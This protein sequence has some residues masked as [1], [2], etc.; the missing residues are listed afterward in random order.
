MPFASSVVGSLNQSLQTRQCVRLVAGRGSDAYFARNCRELRRERLREAGG[1]E[2]L[3]AGVGVQGHLEALVVVARGA[4]VR[5]RRV[6]EDVRREARAGPVGHR[7]ARR[8]VGEVLVE[9]PGRAAARR[10][11]RPCPTSTALSERGKYQ[12]RGSGLRW[13]FI[14]SIRLAS[15]RCCSSACGIETLSRFDPVGHRDAAEQLVRAD[16]ERGRRAT[17]P[18]RRGCPGACTRP[19]ARGRT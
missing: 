5:E 17:G 16:R 9:A 4:R 11:R 3:A 7:A 19:S 10:D 14:V 12:K 6:G 15:R 2:V 13:R 8:A 18:P 1:R